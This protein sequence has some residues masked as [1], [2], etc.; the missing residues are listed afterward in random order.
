MSENNAD[1]SNGF[2][3]TVRNSLDKLVTLTV[4]TRVD[5]GPVR[6]MKTDIRI[7]EGDITNVVHED[8]VG[9]D[10]P[11]LRAFHDSQVAKG[12][13]I[14]RDNIE[15]MKSLFELLDSDETLKD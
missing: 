13:Q 11:Q 4:V 6:E 8:F 15:A 3:T 14:I 12:Q 1:G 2:V 10:L 5:D 9:G 7:L